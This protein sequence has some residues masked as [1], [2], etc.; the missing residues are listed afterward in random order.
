MIDEPKPWIRGS[1]KSIVVI[2][3][4]TG[5]Q[6][7]FSSQG[8]FIL[9]I[10]GPDSRPWWPAGDKGKKRIDVV[11]AL[12]LLQV[13]LGRFPRIDRQEL[14]LESM[15][16]GTQKD[17]GYRRLTHSPAQTNILIS[18]Q[19]DSWERLQPLLPNP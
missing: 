16:R 6:G 10:E 5:A 15:P 14:S 1:P 11:I 4:H 9:A 13:L 17:C 8:E 18:T 2:V 7:E 19:A 12:V 3:A